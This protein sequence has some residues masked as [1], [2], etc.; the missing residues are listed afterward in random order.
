MVQK[1]RAGSSTRSA[2]AAESE[3]TYA[4]VATAAVD[5]QVELAVSP[6]TSLH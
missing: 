1:N 6:F 5:R 2:T 4:R 3:T